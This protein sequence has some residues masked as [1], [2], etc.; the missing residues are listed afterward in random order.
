MTIVSVKP[1]ARVEIQLQVVEP[2]KDEAL[3]AFDLAPA[4]GGTAV[5]W[6]MA[7]TLG[8]FGKTVCLLSSMDRMVGPDLAKGLVRLKA[9]VEE[10]AQHTTATAP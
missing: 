8:F 3:T 1:G 10:E 2:M 4:D 7:G 5:T 6:S 9:V